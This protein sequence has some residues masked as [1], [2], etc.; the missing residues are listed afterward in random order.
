MDNKIGEARR[1]YAHMTASG[2]FTQKDAA[3]ALGVNLGTYRH[4][5]QG[6]GRGL[7]GE[8]LVAIADLYQC[9][10]DY[11]LCR[12]ESPDFNPDARLSRDEKVLISSYRVLDTRQKGIVRDLAESLSPENNSKEEIS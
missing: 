8:Q 11:L 1:A 10:V 7:Y 9:S 5:E 12:T 3:A 2:K 6:I 4:W